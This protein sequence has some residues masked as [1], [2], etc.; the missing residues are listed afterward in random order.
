MNGKRKKAKQEHFSTSST[1]ADKLAATGDALNGLFLPAWRVRATQ[2]KVRRVKKY[3]RWVFPSYCTFPVEQRSHCNLL[4]NGGSA[5]ASVLGAQLANL[6]AARRVLNFQH[7]S[8]NAGSFFYSSL[9][10]NPTPT[11]DIIAARCSLTESVIVTFILVWRCS[12]LILKVGCCLMCA[13]VISQ[14]TLKLSCVQEMS[15]CGVQGCLLF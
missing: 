7:T 10:F 12:I 5:A 11:C 1:H 4:E 9:Q 8:S 3:P 2:P 14:R 6:H 13:Q 15:N